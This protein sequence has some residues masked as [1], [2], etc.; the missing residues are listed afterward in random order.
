ME[1]IVKLITHDKPTGFL[2]APGD[3]NFS[4]T[5]D[6][7]VET[8]DTSAW[9][10]FR[11]AKLPKRGMKTSS[12]LVMRERD[13]WIFTRSSAAPY[14]MRYHHMCRAP[15]ELAAITYCHFALFR[16]PGFDAMLGGRDTLRLLI[17]RLLVLCDILSDVSFTG[18]SSPPTEMDAGDC[19]GR[20]RYSCNGRRPL[21]SAGTMGAG[22][23]GAEEGYKPRTSGEGSSSSV[24]EELVRRVFGP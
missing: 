6:I 1:E 17:R 5:R 10:G 15:S 4:A 12:A 21:V 8:E 2:Y 9:V 22:V 11:V 24:P 14:V 19:C 3:F 20:L 18:R 16:I 13:T 7:L 23:W